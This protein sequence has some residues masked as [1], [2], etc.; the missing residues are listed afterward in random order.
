MLVDNYD[1]FYSRLNS[2]LN[3]STT[4]QAYSFG[5]A[6]RFKENDKPDIYFHFYDL[7]NIRSN[8]ST[9][10]GYGKK[11]T[12]SSLV[13]CGSN[14]LYAAPSY[15]D[16]KKNNSPHYSFGVSRPTKRRQENSPGPIYNVTKKFGEGKP[17]YVFGTSGMNN[18]RR[19]Q[20]C[21]S[22]PGPGAYFNE[23]N[24]DI[25]FNYNSKLL[26]TANIIIGR[27]KRFL[28]KD[29]DKIPGPGSYNIPNLINETGVINFN[30]K[31][32]SVPARSFIGKKSQY[33]FKK[34]DSSPGPGQ[35][36]FF[37]IFEG[38]S[39]NIIKKKK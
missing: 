36:N 20:R 22:V 11:S 5:R 38:Y 34:I 21:S 15:F 12:S 25:S 19:M 6:V 28:N 37:S 29:K 10:L 7:P 31:F 9:T 2:S 8:R 18:P 17:G 30:S 32:M 14:K 26:N 23:K 1:S 16:P 27:E 35:Y 33:K 24:H 3:D 4:K 13:G 39:Q